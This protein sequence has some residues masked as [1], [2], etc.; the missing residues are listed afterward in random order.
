MPLR[1]NQQHV[2]HR[3]RWPQPSGTAFTPSTGMGVEVFFYPSRYP[4]GHQTGG[5]A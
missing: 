4:R 3:Q 2:Q 5:R 1:A